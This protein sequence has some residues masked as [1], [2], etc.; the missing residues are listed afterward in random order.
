MAH[1]ILSS[2]VPQ[3]CCLVLMHHLLFP[4]WF[5]FSQQ[6]FC[7]SRGKMRFL[8][9]L[10][11]KGIPYLFCMPL[12]LYTCQKTTTVPEEGPCSPRIK[13]F[14][15]TLSLSLFTVCGRKF[16]GK[17]TWTKFLSN[18]FPSTPPGA[19]RHGAMCDR[20]SFKVCYVGQV[21]TV[22]GKQLQNITASL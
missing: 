4:Y 17:C 5:S 6:S 1:N 2:E 21:L 11:L 14:G 18:L 10:S 16:A 15:T 13:M 22:E 12:C 19:I 3:Q 20:H 9:A 8:I 7:C